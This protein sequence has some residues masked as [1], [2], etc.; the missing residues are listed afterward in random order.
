LFAG[1][2]G[3][4]IYDIYQPTTVSVFKN[5]LLWR[6]ANSGWTGTSIGKVKFDGFVA[7]ENGVSIF[8][9][10]ETNVLSWSEFVIA[11][12]LF[13]DSTGLP[14]GYSVTAFN[15]FDYS[16]TTV[17]GGPCCQ[18]GGLLLPW[19]TAPGGG[20]LITNCTWVNFQNP[21]IRY[22]KLLQQN[23]V[24][25]YNLIINTQCRSLFISYFQFTTHFSPNSHTFPS[26]VFL[27]ESF[28][29]ISFFSFSVAHAPSPTLNCSRL[30]LTELLTP[31]RTPSTSFFKY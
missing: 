15:E 5:Y 12:S 6:N 29:P 10:R 17:M 3:L 26:A 20:L 22:S 14:L 25:C 2:Y 11:N 27:D 4:R 13:V 18:E 24:S 23:L 1:K 30:F 16:L 8:E 21:C 7:V 19:N 9:G 31:S 28:F